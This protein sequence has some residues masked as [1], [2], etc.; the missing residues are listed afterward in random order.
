[1]RNIII[2]IL[3]LFIVSNISGQR[4]Q[5]AFIFKNDNTL[6]SF[7]Q[8]EI[9]SITHEFIDAKCYQ[10]IKTEQETYSFPVE[11]IDSITFDIPKNMLLEISNENLNGW[12]FGYLFNNEYCVGYRD[13]IDNS[14]VVY[15]N[16]R[17][18]D[19]KNGL[20]ICLS[21]D[22]EVKSIGS[23]DNQC[24]VKIEETQ[25]NLN[26]ITDDGYVKTEVMP[27][28]M[29][30]NDV[31]ILTKTGM[32]R[33]FFYIQVAINFICN[34]QSTTSISKDIL[35]WDWVKLGKD[36]VSIAVES[37][38]PLVICSPQAGVI[39]TIVCSAVDYCKYQNYEKQKK[40]I[41]GDC[42]V[43][44]D[45]IRS[46]NG[47]CTVY[48][49]IL[50]ANTIPDYLM[51]F[52]EPIPDDATRNLVYCGVVARANNKFV[53]NSLN[54][55]MSEEVLLNE[56]V[57]QSPESHYAFIIPNV[58]LNKSHTTYYFRPYLK[59]T[60]L[61]NSKGNVEEGYIKYGETVPYHCFNGEIKEFTQWRSDFDHEYVYFNATIHASIESL[62]DIEEWGVYIYNLYN[63]NQYT[64]YPSSYRAAKLEDFID[65]DVPI[66]KDEFDQV[67]YEN[68]FAVKNIQV[69]IYKK[70]EAPESC[71][72][73]SYFFS[74]P[75]NY[76][77][78]YDKKPKLSFSDAHIDLTNSYDEEDYVLYYT[79]FTFS[80]EADGSFWFDNMNIGL[81]T[82]ITDD[83][84]LI[85][86]ENGDG[87]HKETYAFRY[88]S[89]N[90]SQKFMYL[91]GNLKLGGTFVSDNM[92]M[93]Y[94]KP[95]NSV[96]IE[97]SKRNIEM[98]Q[99]SIKESPNLFEKKYTPV[100]SKVSNNEEFK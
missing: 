61:K 58:Q 100:I 64:Y 83:V 42:T 36:I 31:N 24:N 92:L 29:N 39:I 65:I 15:I 45:D 89:T 80:Y 27:V 97:E 59:S 82:N 17:G 71:D 11:N 49:T 13:S 88:S 76:E 9:E 30:S 54:T 66:N 77:L 25:I 67:N 34:I 79:L 1:M 70:I 14:I 52:Y 37:G 53:T 32:W 84:G 85:K 12:D 3:A 26:C 75:E 8:S 68:Y 72:Y 4:Y 16:K 40:V 86:I 90:S 50:N 99:N 95:I 91:I 10:I 60:R 87:L 81:P 28:S 44:I 48:T 51:N 38:V 7:E 35:N 47:Q 20:M 6:Y 33:P 69:G 18:D 21:E 74:E 22:G 43:S 41:Y 19:L 78:I 63:D 62:D 46:E 57:R 73:L 96:S 55:Q 94:G 98:N 5:G 56:D 2:L 93:F 23:V